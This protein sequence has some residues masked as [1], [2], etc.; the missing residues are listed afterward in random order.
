[1]CDTNPDVITIV[2]MTCPM[3]FAFIT[4]IFCFK[5]CINLIFTSL[6]RKKNYLQVKKF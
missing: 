2:A 1:M 3:I 5:Y 4:D 6:N